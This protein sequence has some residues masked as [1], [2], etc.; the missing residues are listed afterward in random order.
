MVTNLTSIDDA[1]RAPTISEREILNLPI[2]AHG[3]NNLRRLQ[4]MQ[5]ICE[6]YVQR[7]NFSPI[8]EEISLDDGYWSPMLGYDFYTDDDDNSEVSDLD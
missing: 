6:T 5:Y 8:Q 4:L 7:F 2:P 3:N 1:T